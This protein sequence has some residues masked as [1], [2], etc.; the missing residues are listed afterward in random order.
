MSTLRIIFAI[1]WLL[2]ALVCVSIWYSIIFGE[3]FTFSIS[4]ADR[5]RGLAY[6]Y[7][8]AGLIMV[9]VALGVYFQKKIALLIITPLLAFSVLWFI[10]V[11]TAVHLWPK[12]ALGSALLFFI[13]SGSALS[14]LRR[15]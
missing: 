2:V 11:V 10:D 14:L 8:A 6:V 13:S 15:T 5:T 4:G 1:C 7:F 9:L 12:Y 3:A